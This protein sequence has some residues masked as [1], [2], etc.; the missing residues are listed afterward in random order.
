MIFRAEGPTEL[1]QRQR[2][3][4]RKNLNSRP[5]RAAYAYPTKNKKSRHPELVSGSISVNDMIDVNANFKTS[6]IDLKEKLKI[7]T[8]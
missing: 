8:K 6:I 3:W 7:K 2:L 1:S 5:A 4:Y